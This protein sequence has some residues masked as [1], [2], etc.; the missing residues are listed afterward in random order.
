MLALSA[1]ELQALTGY[2]HAS[3][4]IQWVRTQLGLEPPIGADGRPRLTWD[5]VNTA[6]LSRRAGES[7]LAGVSSA[8]QPNWR[9][10]A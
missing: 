3:K 8:P 6:T 4:Q 7:E 2:K 9:R 1:E 10:G 5:V